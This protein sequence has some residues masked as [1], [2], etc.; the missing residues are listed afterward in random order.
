MTPIDRAS[1]ATRRLERIP[2]ARCLTT[3]A[4]P[5]VCEQ[6]RASARFAFTPHVHAHPHACFVLDGVLVEHEGRAPRPLR[7]GDLRLS[8]AGDE[9]RLSV[10]PGGVHCLVVS[11]SPDC[12]QHA[13][14]GP[15]EDR[16]YLDGIRP[17]N[18]A[19]RLLDELQVVDDVSPISLELLVLETLALR[20][21]P[22]PPPARPPGWLR[23][24]RERLVDDF[25]TTPTLAELAHEAGV[26][27]ATLARHFR[28][29]YGCTIGQFLRLR[30]LETARR[31]ILES[32]LPLATV[33][34]RAGFADQSH[35]T[36]LIGS[37]FG[38]PPG[39]LRDSGPP[40]TPA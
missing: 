40:T 28:A 11:V 8:P 2:E 30:R 10:G 33:A 16:R 25:R 32:D 17:S 14:F 18:L 26:G 36:R 35:M 20:A 38:V 31:L 13:G 19:K 9:H 29:T 34:R 22:T 5:V 7:P 15:L 4:W 27:R 1:A 21:V 23:R 6:F 12:L 39:R 24:V 3:T 37:R